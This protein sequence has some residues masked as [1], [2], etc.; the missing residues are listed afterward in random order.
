ME[1][2]SWAHP[3]RH[4]PQRF[5]YVVLREQPLV[6]VNRE[7][8]PKGSP[9]ELRTVNDLRSYPTGFYLHHLTQV[10]AG[11]SIPARRAHLLA[12]SLRPQLVGAPRVRPLQRPTFE[13]YPEQ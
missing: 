10:R 6:R 4:N 11:V 8:A 3:L 12:M 2:V 5:G 13:L 1:A 7:V 9:S